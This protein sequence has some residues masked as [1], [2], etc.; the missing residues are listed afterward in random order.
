MTAAAAQPGGEPQVQPDE[1][2]RRAPT[3][4]AL[5]S[6]RILLRRTLCSG[7]LKS[8][9]CRERPIKKLC[10]EVFPVVVLGSARAPKVS[11]RYEVVLSRFSLASS[12]IFHCVVTIASS[13]RRKSRKATP[14]VHISRSKFL[15]SCER[16]G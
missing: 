1:N 10:R 14:N 4:R 15:L 6:R 11:S 8:N 16:F 3:A 12:G 2:K 13:T 5:D 7:F 9:I